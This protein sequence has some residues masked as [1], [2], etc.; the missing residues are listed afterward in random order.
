MLA[1]LAAE[2]RGTAVTRNRLNHDYSH[3]DFDYSLRAA[4]LDHWCLWGGDDQCLCDD[5]TEPAS[6]EERRGW[7]EA[8]RANV[9]RIDP[10]ARYDV[11]FY[12]DEITEAWNG[13][14]LNMPLNKPAMQGSDIKKYFQETFT[15]AG[16]GDLEGIALGTM[17][18][19]V[20]T[21]EA[22]ASKCVCV[23]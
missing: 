17:G 21:S 22:R 8:H 12:G 13:V 1:V 10:R 3:L 4:A 7:P 23:R 15:T 14:W 9:D 5:F 18:D 20:R 6:R 16:G 11:V 19:T 2:R